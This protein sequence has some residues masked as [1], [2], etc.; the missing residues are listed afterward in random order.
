MAYW[1]SDFRI[2]SIPR[3]QHTMDQERK[4]DNI[5]SAIKTQSIIRVVS[6]DHDL[7]G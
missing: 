2:E 7:D 4:R 1:V 3:F 6:I 5:G